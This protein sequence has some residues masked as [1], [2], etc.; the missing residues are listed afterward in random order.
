MTIV[1]EGAYYSLVTGVAVLVSALSPTS[2]GGFPR[3]YEHLLVTSV[4]SSDLP[5]CRDDGAPAARRAADCQVGGLLFISNGCCWFSLCRYL[6]SNPRL[7]SA[8]SRGVHTP[9]YLKLFYC[10]PVTGKL[11]SCCKCDLL[12]T[13]AQ[14]LKRSCFQCDLLHS[15]AQIL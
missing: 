7:F 13:H 12:H 4:C 15:H 14:F 10:S 6:A 2:R 3:P 9:K 11:S 5:L 1:T 8:C